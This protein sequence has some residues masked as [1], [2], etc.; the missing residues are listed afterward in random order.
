MKT[1]SLILS[2]IFSFVTLFANA[3]NKGIKEQTIKVWGN[4]G[5]CKSTIEKAAKAAGATT[6]I[7]NEDTKMLKVKYNAAKTSND[8]IQ[9]KVAD[10][11][12]DT[13]DLT[14][15]DEV[16]EKLHEC[17]KYD[18]KAATV[19]ADKAKDCCSDKN[20]KDD[21]SCCSDKCSKDSKDCCAKN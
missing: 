12:Y 13:Q 21:K 5:M 19:S 2:A 15:K 16:Y 20:C 11:G 18:R 3:Q 4:C 7:W 14:A 1:R 9:Q 6:A 8:K 17:C 10:A